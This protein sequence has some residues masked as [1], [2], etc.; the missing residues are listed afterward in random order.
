M[1]EI[2]LGAFTLHGVAASALRP[3]S[4]GADARFAG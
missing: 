2:P 1:L 3:A 4:P